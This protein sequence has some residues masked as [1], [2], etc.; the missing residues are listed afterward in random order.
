M[1][2]LQRLFYRPTIREDST[3]SDERSPQRANEYAPTIYGDS[4]DKFN[5]KIIGY[6]KEGDVIIRISPELSQE[7]HDIKPKASITW[8]EPKWKSP[9][10]PNEKEDEAETPRIGRSRHRSSSSVNSK[11]KEKDLS[12]QQIEL[13][14]QQRDFADA[15]NTS[16]PVKNEP[17][18]LQPTEPLS[19]L[20]ESIRRMTQSDDSFKLARLAD[21][22]PDLAE[23]NEKSDKSKGTAPRGDE[24]QE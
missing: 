4:S 8:D 15:R 20:G 18:Q 14:Q 7:I 11:G 10:T 6:T 23:Q 16:L 2:C 13:A 9:L 24:E 17:E 19:P 12:V 3:D 5:A 21:W 22:P 1:K